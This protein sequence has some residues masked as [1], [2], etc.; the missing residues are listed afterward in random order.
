ML[1]Y[2]PSILNL[3]R[4]LSLKYIELTQTP[5]LHLSRCAVI[6]VLKSVCVVFTVID[7]HIGQICMPGMK[8]TCPCCVIISVCFWIQFARIILTILCLCSARTLLRFTLFGC[9][10]MQLWFQ[11]DSCFT[12]WVWYC[13]FPS[14]LF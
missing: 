1:K 8:P 11:D 12:G 5:L 7:S 2:I 13:S 14:H 6:S 4:L 9:V 3:F 10:H